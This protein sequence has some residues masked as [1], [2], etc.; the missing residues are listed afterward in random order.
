[1]QASA[2]WWDDGWQFQK[3]L[4]VDISAIS[5]GDNEKKFPVLIKLS[6]GN[7]KYFMDVLPKGEDLRFVAA[8][9]KTVLNYHIEKF[10]P[11]TEIALIW[12][13]LKI[14]DT[15]SSPGVSAETIY[16]YYGNAAAVAGDN[17]ANTYDVNQVLVYH[18]DAQ[19]EVLDA[20]AYQ[21]NPSLTTATK[22]PAGIIGSAASF[23]VD[24]VL[25]LPLSPSLQYRAEQ[26]Y[27]VSTWLKLNE[28]INDTHIISFDGSTSIKFS[29]KDGGLLA[30]LIKADEVITERQIKSLLNPNKWYQLGFSVSQQQTD[31]YIDGKIVVTLEG[32]AE[33]LLPIISIGKSSEQPGFNGMLDELNVANSRRSSAWFTTSYD[34]LAMGSDIVMFGADES[35]EEGVETESYFVTILSDVSLDGRIV[36]FL[37]GL[38]A[39]SSAVVVLGKVIMLVRVKKDNKKFMGAFRELTSEL[40]L[41]DREQTEEEKELQASPFLNAAFGKHDHYQ[42]SNLYHLYHVAM[43]ELKNRIHGGASISSQSMAATK[44]TLDAAFVREQQVLNKSMVMLTIAISGGPFLGLLGTVL[45]VMITFAAI[46]TSGEVDINAIAP[47]VA[48]ALMTTVAGLAVAIPALF[49]YNFL[50]T[51]IRDVSIDMRVFVDELIARI[52]EYHGR[53]D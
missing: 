31:I 41:I 50:S 24:Q 37:L 33:D 7:F 35:I 34:N 17:S 1:M 44:A 9:Q 38:M 21:N 29:V 22:D 23:T 46:A 39:A 11:V 47:G 51:R 32:I 18:F 53:E 26:G 12:V 52:A 16:M 8:D 4:T 45:G 14:G 15:V 49:S 20:T 19:A 10:D 2:D 42:S 6:G 48:A 13:Q 30:S 25:Q 36:I 5:A 40:T 27:S 28:V 43:G 3:Q